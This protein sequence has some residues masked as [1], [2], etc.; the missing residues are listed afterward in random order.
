MAK[1][2][3]ESID[4]LNK[5]RVKGFM[6]QKNSHG[7]CHAKILSVQPLFCYG[8]LAEILASS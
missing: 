3:L 8:S 6:G 1:P 7:Q 2:A 4:Y 5:A